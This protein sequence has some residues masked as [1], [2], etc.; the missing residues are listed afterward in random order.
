MYLQNVETEGNK[1]EEGLNYQ[2]IKEETTHKEILATGSPVGKVRWRQV[3][4]SKSI[5]EMSVYVYIVEIQ[6]PVS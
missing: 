5:Q 6:T 1:K 2:D 3:L 4:F